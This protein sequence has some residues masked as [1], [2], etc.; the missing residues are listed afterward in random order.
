MDEPVNQLANGSQSTLGDLL[1]LML[2]DALLSSF[3]I[4]APSDFS[5]E[6]LQVVHGTYHLAIESND[7]G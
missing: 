2:P 5:M 1:D 7:T 6:R 4:N 3:G